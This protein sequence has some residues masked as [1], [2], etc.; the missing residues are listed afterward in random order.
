[1]SVRLI[2]RYVGRIVRQGVLEIVHADGTTSRLGTPADGF[3]EVRIRF[4]DTRVARDI[5]LDP[6]L[7]AGEAFI[8]GRLIIEQGDVM[9]LAALFRA[10][11]PWERPD[12][13]VERGGLRRLREKVATLAD[14]INRT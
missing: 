2:E 8:A 4:T 14:G 3:P 12:R 10:N 13:V 5:M 6:R 9:D 11:G 1:M 7:G